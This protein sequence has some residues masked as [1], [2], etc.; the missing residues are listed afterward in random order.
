MPYNLFLIAVIAGYFILSYSQLFKYNIQRFSRERILF[1]SILAGF[2][3]IVSGF[4]FRIIF[5]FL[6]CGKIIPLLLN[7]L[8]KFPIE[9]PQYFWT[10]IFSSLIS[11]LLAWF[12]NW[13]IIR[14]YSEN[15]QIIRAVDKNGDEIEKLFKDSAINGNLIQVTLKNDKVYVGFCEEIPIPKKTNYLKLSPYLSGY[16]HK[17]TKQLTITTDYEKVVDEFISE[18]KETTGEDV[19]KI[20]LNTDVIIKQDE[21]LTATIYEQKVFDKFNK[22]QVEPEKPKRG[23]KPTTDK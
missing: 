21:I 3:I 20:T 18:I 12:S 10:F 16:R 2:L 17:D 15:D 19:D 23:R 6:T 7:C 9:K 11:I 8:N 14:Y 22:P 13:V 4:I 5:D 1:E